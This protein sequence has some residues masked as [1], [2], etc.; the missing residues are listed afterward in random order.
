M[1]AQ[2]ETSA[3]LEIIQDKADQL[4][5]L[6]VAFMGQG[7]VPMIELSN[8]HQ[9]SPAVA[10]RPSEQR[11]S[12]TKRTVA[13]KEDFAAMTPS[14]PL[15]NMYADNDRLDYSEGFHW[16]AILDWI[17]LPRIVV[18]TWKLV[19]MFSDCGSTASARQQ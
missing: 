19:M 2:N 15:K 17:R 13:A 6:M 18:L 16:S 10:S 11:E 1:L 12:V 14:E 9:N 8:S 3:N 4:E 7:D 5:S